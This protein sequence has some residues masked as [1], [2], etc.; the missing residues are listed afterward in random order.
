LALDPSANQPTVFEGSANR[1]GIYFKRSHHQ[2]VHH[3][4][5]RCLP[6]NRNSAEGSFK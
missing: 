6:K 5:S 2:V 3:M 4:V 1:G